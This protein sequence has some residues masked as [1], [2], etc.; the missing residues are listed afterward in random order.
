MFYIFTDMTTP[1]KKYTLKDVLDAVDTNDL[2]KPKSSLLTPVSDASIIVSPAPP[3]S[4]T[5][6]A[7]SDTIHKL[8]KI[9]LK[10]PE[11]TRL[12]EVFKVVEKTALMRN[13][14]HHESLDE[15]RKQ[16]LEEQNARS[17]EAKIS[18][19]QLKQLQKAL[20]DTKE[21]LDEEKEKN[22]EFADQLRAEK[23]KRKEL[24]K[25]LHREQQVAQEA[26]EELENMKDELDKRNTRVSELKE[27][28][29]ELREEQ[30]QH[31]KSTRSLETVRYVPPAPPLPSPPQGINDASTVPRCKDHSRD[32]RYNVNK[33]HPKYDNYYTAMNTQPDQ[34]SMF[35]PSITNSS[36]GGGGHMIPHYSRC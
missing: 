36:G 10:Q 27:R 22:E 23:D 19:K 17:R 15:L 14:D 5:L 31:L 26:K 8:L 30:K 3:K 24:Q 7:G 4:S 33:G 1:I 32:M 20:E 21:Q 13:K 34:M 29:R 6:L 28:V 9:A 35:V 2:Y 25:Q 18:R 16:L 11:E 12:D